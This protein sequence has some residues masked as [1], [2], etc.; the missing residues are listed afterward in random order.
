MLESSFPCP[1]CG[2]FMFDEPPGSYAICVIC[3][4]EDDSVQ[5]RHP[6]MRGGANKKSLVEYQIEIL[7]QIPLEIK[8]H[9][10]EGQAFHRDPEW[11]PWHPT[12]DIES[13]KE[14]PKTGYEYS[15]A[16]GNEAETPTYYWR[17]KN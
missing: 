4:W 14:M 12:D 11:R 15:L 17:K 10:L 6:T 1:S 9:Q 2:F 3:N 16:V 8:T 13:N 7:K 5:L